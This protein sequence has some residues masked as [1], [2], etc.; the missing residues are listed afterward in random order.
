MATLFINPTFLV[1]TNDTS[2][3]KLSLELKKS[4][5]EDK[6]IFCKINV[7]GSTYKIE[8][9][10]NAIIYRDFLAD[11]KRIAEDRVN[12]HPRLGLVF[13]FNTTTSDYFLS[14]EKFNAIAEDIKIEKYPSNPSLFVIFI[15]PIGLLFS[16]KFP[17]LGLTDFITIHAKRKL[18]IFVYEQKNHPNEKEAAIFEFITEAKKYG[19]VRLISEST[20]SNAAKDWIEMLE[21]NFDVET[22]AL[23]TITH[24]TEPKTYS[25]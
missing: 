14:R 10:E 24:K 1:F 6:P 16:D 8:C 12:R 4:S 15:C 20:I 17:G 11:F 18:M 3:L 9:K 22:L 21:D 25:E 13:K 2:D 5:E 19:P 23:Y 7:D